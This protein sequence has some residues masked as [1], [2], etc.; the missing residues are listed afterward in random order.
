MEKNQLKK[1]LKSQDLS[2]N[3]LAQ[4]LAA[5]L[6]EQDALQRLK[7]SYRALSETLRVRA[8]SRTEPEL[9]QRIA[10]LLKEYCQ[11]KYVW[12]GYLENDRDKTIRPVA[13]SE[14]TE[15][16]IQ[17]VQVSW[18]EG[19]LGQGAVG[20]SIRQLKPVVLDNILGNPRFSPWKDS[21]RQYGFHSVAALPLIIDQRAFGFLVF[22]SE[23][24][25]S[26]HQEELQLLSEIAGEL[27]AGVQLLREHNKR[28]EVQVQLNKLHQAVEQSPVSIIIT[29][30]FGVIEY[31]NPFFTTITGFSAPEAIGK[32][33]RIVSSGKN[34][35]QLIR[36]LWDKLLSGQ[37][38]SGEFINR[39]KDGREFIEYAQIAPVFSDQGEI[40]HFIAVKEDITRR[41]Q[42]EKKLKR[43]AHFDPLTQLPN[44]A[45]FYDR[46]RQS[47]ALAG[48]QQQYCALLFID[49]NNFKQINDNFGHTTGDALLRACAER[50]SST[51]RSSDTVARI[52][53]DE[54]VII[55]NLLTNSEAAAGLAKK[56]L[57]V[58]QR[59][60]QLLGNRCE[61]GASIGISIYP[62]HGLDSDTLIHKADQAM[63]RI[64]KQRRNAFEFY[65]D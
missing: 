38:W 26:Y 64:K 54:F 30:K 47:I 34:S 40:T 8:D 25:E 17:Q 12:I 51:I 45:L 20:Q 24:G 7:R 13:W 59:P 52:G 55:S 56:I 43:L 42:L 31:V 32:T 35:P 11:Y 57:D 15:G 63:Y 36:N 23:A 9:L 2:E 10:K 60:F 27:S 5:T 29:D 22:H 18:G 39:T 58:L 53:G 44:R 41:K 28:E 48:R 16:F 6:N 61:I 21:A 46:L 4:A 50:L 49:L 33:P 62:D 1:Q 3:G 65:Q 14:E 37:N 19:P